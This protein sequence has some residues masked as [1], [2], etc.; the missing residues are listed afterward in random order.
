M[1][2]LRDKE[3]RRRNDCNEE[4]N[5]EEEF[6]DERESDLETQISFIL[7]QKIL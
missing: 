2:S 4:I 5:L 7:I 6:V 1:R 3:E